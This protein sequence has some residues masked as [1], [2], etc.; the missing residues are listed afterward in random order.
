MCVC[1]CLRKDC[2]GEREKSSVDQGAWRSTGV[3]LPGEVGAWHPNM[4]FL[5]PGTGPHASPVCTL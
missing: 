4:G 2:V 1:M 5:E 3:A